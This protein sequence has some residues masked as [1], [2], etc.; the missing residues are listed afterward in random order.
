MTLSKSFILYL[1]VILTNSNCPSIDVSYICK[2][3]YKIEQ[4]QV[5]C[6]ILRHRLDLLSEIDFFLGLDS[7]KTKTFYLK[8]NIT[9]G[10][11]RKKKQVY[12]ITFILL[13][14]NTSWF[15]HNPT[16]LFLFQ[17]SFISTNNTWLQS[18][19]H[20]AFKLFCVYNVYILTL[21]AIL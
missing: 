7:Y 9:D 16:N 5:F 6:N 1:K 19:L 10:T 15:S 3:S 18:R 14:G 2:I 17:M 11:E 21:P 12:K 13:Q 8:K 20:K 4:R